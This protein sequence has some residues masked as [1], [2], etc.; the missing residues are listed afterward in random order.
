MCI[1]IS[2][3]F[4]SHQC[5]PHTIWI[6]FSL[7]CVPSQTQT[8]RPTMG[9]NM[10]KKTYYYKLA[11]LSIMSLHNMCHLLTHQ[12]GKKPRRGFESRSYTNI[13]YINYQEMTAHTSLT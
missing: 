1:S 2:Y 7:Q 13:L 3:Y 11:E 10:I 8:V 4:Y 5:Q 12:K 9:V 6:E